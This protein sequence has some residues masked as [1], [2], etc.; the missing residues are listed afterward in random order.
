MSQTV[1]ETRAAVSNPRLPISYLTRRFKMVA[2]LVAKRR[3]AL[4]ARYALDQI[5]GGD[6]Y[7][8]F[9]QSNDDRRYLE[10]DVLD[11]RMRVDL[12]DEGL[13]RDLVI[14]GLREPRATA[15]YRAELSRFE[16]DRGGLTVVDIGANIGYFALLYLTQCSD[17]GEVIAIEPVPETFEL[18][19]ENLRLNGVADAV[20]CYQCAFGAASGSASMHLSKHRNLSA[21]TDSP[22]SHHTDEITVPVESL[23][24]FLSEHGIAP[25][26]VDVL[27]MDIQGYEYEVFQGMSELLRNG[28]VGLVFLELHPSTLKRTGSYDEFISMLQEAGFELVF[29][30]DGRT[31][32]LQ[33]DHPTY[34]DREIEIDSIEAMRDIDITVE[35]ILRKS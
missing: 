17:G 20:D 27:R 22:S 23:D 10:C 11:F 26:S 9:L 16:A 13:S 28:S 35:I 3:Y 33:D 29:A 21:I 32:N 12:L 7:Q 34:S 4:G 14:D 6:R 18:L 8:S 24:G 15:R 30:A 2:A 5:D 1:A 25:E 31:T 19:L